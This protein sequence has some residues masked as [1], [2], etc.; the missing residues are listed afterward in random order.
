MYI[1]LTFLIQCQQ[2][3]NEN[4]ENHQLGEMILI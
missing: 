4:V 2:T 1:L 3:G